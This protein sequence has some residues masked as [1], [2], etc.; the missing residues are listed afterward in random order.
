MPF[1]PGTFG[2]FPGLLWFLFLLLAGNFWL[3]LAGILLGIAASVWLCGK[4]EKLL[5]Q[6]DPSSVVLDEIIAVPICFVPWVAGLW[7]HSGAFPEP[8]A[9]F[10]SK[11]WWMTG[12]IFALF[13][14]FDIL[15]PWPVKQ[16]Q[17][18]PGGW[19]VTVD[20][21]LAAAYVAL[22]SLLFIS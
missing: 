15:K 10:T 16:S 17:R 3:F 21:V 2:T 5:L 20:D 18:L 1:A 4:A 12:A 11:T 14:V 9:F 8:A 19:G 13:R 7:H 22:V 6:K